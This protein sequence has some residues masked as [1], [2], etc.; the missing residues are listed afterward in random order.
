VSHARGISG[1]WG[2]L[3]RL[4]SSPIA[5]AATLEHT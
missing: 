2:R 1:R 3:K 5:R 4:A